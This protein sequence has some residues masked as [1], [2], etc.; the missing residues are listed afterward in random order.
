[1][2]TAQLHLP[3][4]LL[5]ALLVTLP[6][7]LP[8]LLIRYVLSSN[9]TIAKNLVLLGAGMDA[10]TLYF[11]KSFEDLY[12]NKKNSAGQS[13]WAFSPGTVQAVHWH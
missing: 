7:P 3:P 1:V 13:Q 8:L 4:L 12:G 5:L 9:F 11:T 2:L 6:P 10:T